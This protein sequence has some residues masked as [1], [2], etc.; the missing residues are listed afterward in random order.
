MREGGDPPKLGR[1][2]VKDATP[3]VGEQIKQAGGRLATIFNAMSN[4]LFAGRAT[5]ASAHQRRHFFESLYLT[6]SATS[7][8]ICSS[9]LCGGLFRASAP[10]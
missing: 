2:Y 9:R 5:P 6:A 7:L 3:V 10:R 8:L 1:D 4:P